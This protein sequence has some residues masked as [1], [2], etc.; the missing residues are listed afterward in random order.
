MRW[1]VHGLCQG[2]TPEETTN[3]PFRPLPPPPPQQKT[4]GNTGE[5]YNEWR[6]NTD[7]NA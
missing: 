2:T 5:G 4:A 3:T 6:M 1:S 7:Q